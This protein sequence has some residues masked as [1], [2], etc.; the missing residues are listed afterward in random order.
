MAQFGSALVWGARGRKFKSCRPDH[1]KLNRRHG[2]KSH[3]D[4]FISNTRFISEVVYTK[5]SN[6]ERK[7]HD[8]MTAMSKKQGYGKVIWIG[9][10]AVV[11]GHEALAL[12]LKSA[13][14]D[15]SLQSSTEDRLISPFYT[16]LVT[17]APNLFKPIQALFFQLKEHFASPPLLVEIDLNMPLAAGMG[18]SAAIAAALTRTFYDYFDRPLELPVLYEWIQYAEALAHE[19]PSGVDATVIAYEKPLRFMKG[20]ASHFIEL[21]REGYLLVMDSG[22][23]GRTKDAVLSI[24]STMDDS[25]TQQHIA[26]LGSLSKTFI[27]TLH[28]ATLNTLGHYMNEAH[29]HLKALGVSAKTLDDMCE[30]AL[31]HGALGAKL[32]GGGLGGCMMALMDT[33]ATLDHVIETFHEAGYRRYWVLNLR[34]DFS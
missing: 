3:D 34:E 16:G 26:I 27:E 9:E 18:S 15:V 20:E 17:N 5:E 25:K 10:H 2:F 33:K 28:T 32:T 13:S 30:L 21:K 7:R 22:L 19:K 14:V 11:Y 23:K 6:Y 1:F 29:T 24:R 31:Q 4:F 8:T 12:P